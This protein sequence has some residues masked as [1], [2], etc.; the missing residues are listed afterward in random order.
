MGYSCTAAAALKLEA[1][2]KGLRE[3]GLT[4]YHNGRPMTNTWKRG[5]DTLFYER[6]RENPDGAITGS[7]FS[8]SGRRVGSFRIEPDGQVTRFPGIPKGI[9]EQTRVVPRVDS[10][11]GSTLEFLQQRGLNEPSDN[12]YRRA[13][14]PQNPVCELQDAFLDAGGRSYLVDLL[15]DLHHGLKLYVQGLYFFSTDIRKDLRRVATGA[16]LW[17]SIRWELCW[18]LW[19]EIQYRKNLLEEHHV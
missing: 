16:S 11:K 7:I 2:M 17:E 14:S 10:L 8:I 15:D 6:G 3:A 18:A 12:L 5:K 13:F 4:V 1:I 9:R 19:G